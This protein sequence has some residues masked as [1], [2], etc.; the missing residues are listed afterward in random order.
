M[1]G[2]SEPSGDA[3]PVGEETGVAESPEQTTAPPAQL[4]AL[5]LDLKRSAE[6]MESLFRNKIQLDAGREAMIDRLHAE[7][8]EYK[9][10][11]AFKILKPLANG[12]INLHDDVGKLV[13][14]SRA[15]HD[16]PSANAVADALDSVRDDIEDTLEQAGFVAFVTERADFDPKRQ[17]AV[18]T[19]PTTEPGLDRTVAERLRK[20]FVY[21]GKLV[22]PELVNVYIAQ[23]PAQV[24]AQS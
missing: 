9:D 4:T 15:R 22:R 13:V 24:E 23:T 18:R 19:I 11:L 6:R 5:L 17:R 12:L 3:L 1:T 8:Q 10:D 21:D 2:L 20:G 16:D 7:I 14:A